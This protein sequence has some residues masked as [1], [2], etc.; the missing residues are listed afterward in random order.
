[1]WLEYA[2]VAAAENNLAGMQE[3]AEAIFSRA[4][5]PGQREELF[6]DVDRYNSIVIEPMARGDWGP[7]SE[8]YENNCAAYV[9]VRSIP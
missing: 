3:A 5:I 6:P 2:S 7:A 8:V 1:M 9:E 4:E